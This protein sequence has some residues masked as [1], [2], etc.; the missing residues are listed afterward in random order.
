MNGPGSG[1]P[2]VEVDE[3]FPSLTTAM[4]GTQPAT[5]G[6]VDEGPT[7]LTTLRNVLG[8]RPRDNDPKAFLAALNSSFSLATVE[9]TVVATY[10]PRSF[11]LQADLGAVT[12]GQASLYNRAKAALDQMLPIL[13]GLTPLR[14][15]ADPDDCDALRALVR[16]ALTN[17][18]DELGTPGGPRVARVDT[19]LAVLV[20]AAHGQ[21]LSGTTADGVLGQLG[22]LRETFGLEDKWVNTVE[23]EQIRTSFWTLSDLVVDLNN[24]WAGQRGQ[25][26]R[27][28]GNAAGFLGT[29]LVLISRALAAAADQVADLE[30]ILDSVFIPKSERQTLWLHN[31]GM[32]VDDGLSWMKT[33]LTEEAVRIVTEGGRDGIEYT[34]TP[35]LRQLYNFVRNNLDTAPNSRGAVEL[36]QPT[37]DLPAGFSAGRTRLALTNLRRLLR[38][39]YILVARVHREPK[40]HIFDVEI[41]GVENAPTTLRIIARVANCR[42]DLTLQLHDTTDPSQPTL[43]AANVTVGGDAVTGLFDVSLW[44]KVVGQTESPTV[45]KVD[46]VDAPSGVCLDATYGLAYLRELPAPQPVTGAAT[47]TTRRTT[48]R[49]RTTR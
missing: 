49:P 36:L 38:E 5:T 20:D 12:G 31:A 37:R 27:V 3:I 14:V 32:T 21:Q 7:V 24:S 8:W 11:A 35:I 1:I 10:T 26:T 15:D 47:A 19:Y 29:D 42:D 48:S 6:E 30:A 9:G 40:P 4:P 22:R 43:S 2:V 16:D 41:E 33:V 17:V 46:V 28:G 44:N 18:V 23:D 13:D 39:L 45:V 25:F 34:L